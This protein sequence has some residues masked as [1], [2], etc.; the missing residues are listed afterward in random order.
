MCA[1]HL[2][3]VARFSPDV[4]LNA[5]ACCIVV[6]GSVVAL[7]GCNRVFKATP[8]E[9]VGYLRE[10]VRARTVTRETAPIDGC[11][12]NRFMTGVPAW[13]DSLVPA[14]QAMIVSDTVPC[15]DD[16]AP[17]QGRFVLTHWY[18]NW[19]GEY[20]IRGALYPWDQGYRFTD[21]V[22]VGREK[23]ENQEAQARFAA[24]R[25]AASADS[26]DSVVLRGDSI[27]RAG[28]VSDSL[29]D[30]TRDSSTSRSR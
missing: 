27:R 19:S 14:E 3:M 12:V 24:Q 17:M 11:S 5:T 10:L 4:M 28:M 7:T 30:V 29:N 25:A 9:R 21:G 26:G 2:P 20:V 15:T 22:Y 16:G 23:I 18:R 1:R 13:R 6:L 8:E